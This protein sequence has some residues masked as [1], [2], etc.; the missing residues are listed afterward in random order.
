MYLV[1]LAYKAMNFKESRQGNSSQR[2]RPEK[3]NHCALR[4]DQDMTSGKEEAGQWPH[5]VHTGLPHRLVSRREHFAH[6]SELRADPTLRNTPF[7]HPPRT[8][9]RD[10][11]CTCTCYSCWGHLALPPPFLLLLFSDMQMCKM[12]V[13]TLLGMAFHVR[14]EQDTFSRPQYG[15]KAKECVCPHA[16]HSEA[17]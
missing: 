17:P 8:W 12:S 6:S 13:L 11:T 5:R 9:L 4:A 14:E 2:P 15:H 10:R 7:S 16:Y 3:N 1:L